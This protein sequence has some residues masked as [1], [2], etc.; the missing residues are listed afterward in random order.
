M[1]I[2]FPSTHKEKLIVTSNA[3]NFHNIQTSRLV[4][5][6][7]NLIERLKEPYGSFFILD[8]TNV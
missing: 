3:T 5:L 6:S 7:I 1:T 4:N 2:S 8:L